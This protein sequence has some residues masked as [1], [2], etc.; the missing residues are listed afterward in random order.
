MAATAVTIRLFTFS[1]FSARERRRVARVDVQDVAGR[2]AGA[3]AREEGDRFRHVLGVDV[4]L[5]EAALAIDLLEL[6]L[7]HA[8]GGGALLPPVALPDLAAAQDGVGVDR[9]DAD[10]EVGAFEGEA[11]RQ[12]E[13]RRFRRAVGRGLRRGG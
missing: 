11:A 6:L 7:L 9:V 10:A 2:L 1:S 3:L 8:V 5:Q 4:A 13:F 12:M